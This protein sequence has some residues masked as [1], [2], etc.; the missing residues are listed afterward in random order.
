M[1]ENAPMR[2][3]NRIAL[4]TAGSLLA[5]VAFA[6][7]VPAGQSE[8]VA[9]LRSKIMAS[10]AHQ[11]DCFGRSLAMSS[12]YII[13]GAKGDDMIAKD[14]GAAYIF[15][16][17]NGDYVQMAKLKADHPETNDYFGFSVA[18]DGETAVVG[19][20]Q[21]KH[22]GRDAGAAYVFV[23]QGDSWVLQSK[24]T[25]TDAS[26]FA[27]FGYTVGISGERIVV[28]AR[29]E[30]R[31]ASSAGA[32]YVFHRDGSAWAQEAKLT[33]AAPAADQQFGWSVAI[34]GDRV[35][36]GAL[37]DK[38]HG[39]ESGAAYLFHRAS[40]GWVRDQRLVPPDPKVEQRFGYSVSLQA[41]S[42]VVGAYR[43]NS[44]GY[45]SGAAY[46]YEN[47]GKT[48]TEGQKLIASDAR[49]SEYFGWSVAVDG[50]R[51]VVGAWYDGDGSTD[52][53]GSVYVFHK[54]GAQWNQEKKL[55]ANQRT[56]MHLFGW[57]VAVNG[58]TVAVGARLDDEAAD[59]AGAVYL[60]KSET[61][62][63]ALSGGS[64]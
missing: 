36:V 46:V 15:E 4:L 35:L 53:L 61:P 11:H 14:S 39:V 7:T 29:E 22:K 45:E 58:P 63:A 62:V 38:Y 54:N 34:D 2:L 21:D 19:A 64:Y 31:I 43:D 51:V 52:P 6:Q 24:L 9:K 10:D 30:S 33:A 26:D 59:K 32:A 56:P 37:G 12:K 41:N 3:T 23:R 40:N 57:A 20:W 48:W 25:A 5:A 55:I 49:A 17:R 50:A 42:A 16:R 44:G 8:L 47:R 28:G 13:A 27:H 1:K 18:I 60:Y